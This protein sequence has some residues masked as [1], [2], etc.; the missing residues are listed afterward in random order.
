MAIR[1]SDVIV[2]VDY[3]SLWP[4][5][6]E[7]ARRRIAGE[8]GPWVAQVEHIG[9]TSVPGL[10][11]KPIIDIMVGLLKLGDAAHCIGP[12]EALGYEYVPEFE[13][14]MPERRYFRM[15]DSDGRWVH[16]VHMVEIGGEFWERDLLFRDYLRS[17]PKMASEYARLKRELAA[18]FVTNDGERYT[19]AKT[20]FIRGV[21]AVARAERRASRWP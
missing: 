13:R 20:P 8:I 4:E 17:H 9:S 6:F 10:A 21:E 7:V 14:E 19:E 1:P 3:D 2:I 5:M 18:R 15:V 16:H 11:A 12:L